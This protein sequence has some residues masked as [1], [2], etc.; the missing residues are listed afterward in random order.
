MLAFGR[1]RSMALGA[2]LNVMTHCNGRVGARLDFGSGDDT[3]VL[4][5][6]VSFVLSGI[7]F[8][9]SFKFE[10]VEGLRK[11]VGRPKIVCSLETSL[12]QKQDDFVVFLL[13]ND[14]A[15]A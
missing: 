14:G 9:R 3:I 4:V 5:H 12:F 8:S 11:R 10:V 13:C 15:A 2:G 6:L 1:I 7:L